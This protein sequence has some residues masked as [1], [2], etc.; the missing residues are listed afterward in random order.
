[1]KLELSVVRFNIS[2]V[3]TASGECECE[4]CEV[5]MEGDVLE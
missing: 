3:I 4:I 5:L 1:M 2:D